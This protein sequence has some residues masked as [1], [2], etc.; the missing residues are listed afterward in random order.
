MPGVAHLSLPLKSPTAAMLQR[1]GNMRPAYEA[2]VPIIRKGEGSIEDQYRRQATIGR[3]GRSTAW[4]RPK[5]F[6]TDA[7]FQARSLKRT[8][9]YLAA[10]LGEGPGAEVRIG[11]NS[12]SVGV[13][14][15]AFPQL[16]VLQA[17]RPT[18]IK[19]TQNMRGYLGAVKGVHLRR[20]TQILIVEPRAFRTNPAMVRRARQALINYV[21]NGVGKEHRAGAARR[22]A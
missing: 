17:S 11:A 20:S 3:G 2:A 21:I 22:A 7:K 12:V 1:M 15:S 5:P 6:G 4:P 19:V 14:R 8:G 10:W 13:D 9:R 18:A 16:G